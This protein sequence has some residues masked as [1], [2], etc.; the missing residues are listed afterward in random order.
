MAVL[1]ERLD[2][3]RPDARP[4]RRPVGDQR[5]PPVARRGRSPARGDRG[6]HAPVRRAPRSFDALLLGRRRATWTP[7]ATADRRSPTGPS[8]STPERDALD[9]GSSKRRGGRGVPVL[10]I[11]RGL[12]VVNVALGGTL[13][14]DIPS[15]RPSAVVHARTRRRRRG[16]ITASTVAPGTRLARIAGASEVVGQQPASSG[17]RDGRARPARLGVAPDG[18]PEAVEARGRAVARG[19][20]VASGEPRRRS[21]LPR[22]SSQSSFG[23]RAGGGAAVVAEGIP[24]RAAALSIADS[25]REDSRRTLRM[26]DPRFRRPVPGRR[27]RR[28]AR[29]PIRFHKGRRPEARRRRLGR[30]SPRRAPTSAGSFSATASSRSTRAATPRRARQILEAIAR[31]DGRQARARARPD[32]RARGPRRRRARLRGGRRPRDLPGGRGRPDPRLRDAGGA[33][34]PRPDGRQAGPAAGRRVHLGALSS[35]STASTTSRSTSSAAAHTQGRSRRLP[36]HRQDALRRRPRLERPHALHAVGRR[37]S[38]PG[39]SA[40]SPRSRRFRPRRS[41]PGTATSGPRR[42]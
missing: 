39:G 20:P 29:G 17:D 24:G 12:Q 21:G 30:H 37:G 33:R 42:W 36:P 3:H 26:R 10:G 38:R 25:E 40:R 15:E 13:V 27:A 32:A 9:F 22:G 14:Q 1:F 19:R 16:A 23:A 11:C 34:I 35:C 28:A 41:F 4:R 2:A 5:L 31:D 6:R 18:V 7:R 8:R